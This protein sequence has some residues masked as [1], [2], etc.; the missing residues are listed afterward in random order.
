MRTS[1]NLPGMAINLPSLFNSFFADEFLNPTI[2]RLQAPAVNI[3]E[4]HEQ[5]EIE[6]VAPGYEK[7]QFNVKVEGNQLL[8]SAEVKSES[9]T[10]EPNFRHREF[11]VASFERTFTLPKGKVNTDAIC[12][13]YKN[14]ILTLMLPKLE[15]AKPKAPK[16][17]SIE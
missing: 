10:S 4:K 17:I 6:V 9:E 2:S 5:F 14:G 3:A 12:A 7:E 1:R 8:I 11:R 13:S 16:L 15:E